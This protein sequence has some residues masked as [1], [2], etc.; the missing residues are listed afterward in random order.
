[1]I[2]P[3]IQDF[4]YDI[5]INDFQF[6]EIRGFGGSN[7]FSQSYE[8]AD[9]HLTTET[10]DT[11]IFTNYYSDFSRPVPETIAETNSSLNAG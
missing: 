8:P 9:E 7:S 4:M 1:M 11:S 3:P 2:I 6:G 5:P 10:P